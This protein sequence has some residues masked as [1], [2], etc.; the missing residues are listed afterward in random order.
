[1][2]SVRHWLGRSLH[3]AVPGASV[4]YRSYVAEGIIHFLNYKIS[5]VRVGITFGRS[6]GH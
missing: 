5:C 6:D 4:C 2:N 3:A 1:M